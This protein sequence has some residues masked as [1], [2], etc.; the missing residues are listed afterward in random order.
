MQ[1]K[2]FGVFL[3]LVLSLFY[4]TLATAADNNAGKIIK[5]L[6]VINQNEIAAAKIAAHKSTNAAVKKYAALMQEAHTLNLNETLKIS[7]QIKERPMDSDISKLLKE[8]GK[9]ELQSLKEAKKD[10]DTLYIGDMVKDHT[11]ALNFLDDAILK[12]SGPLQMHLKNT[13]VHVQKHLDAAIA[14]QKQ[15]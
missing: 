1:F 15:L 4:V 3:S 13:R 6:V 11:S 5:V 10:F 8:N 9:K 7:H 14:I 12:T 2:K